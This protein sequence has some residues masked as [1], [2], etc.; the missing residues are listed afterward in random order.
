MKEK[1]FPTSVRLTEKEK[2]LLKTL[3]ERFEKTNVGDVSENDVIRLAL[4]RLAE[5]EGVSEMNTITANYRVRDIGTR[6]VSHHE[7]LEQ[8][9]DATLL[10][11]GMHGHSRIDSKVNGEWEQSNINDDI[12]QA[13]EI[14]LRNSQIRF[15][16]AQYQQEHLKRWRTAG[17]PKLSD[18]SSIWK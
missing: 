4:K 12:S 8:A 18:Y 7:T 13:V 9:I 16:P 2:L 15:V 14:A 11:E 5:A 1:T 17:S 10:I 6:E 3:V